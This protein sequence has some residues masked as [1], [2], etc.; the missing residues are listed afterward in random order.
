MREKCVLD[1]RRID[2]FTPRNNHVFHPIVNEHITF[3]IKEPRIASVEIAVTNS[4]L[5]GRI[6]VPIA[7][8][9][10]FS[11]H[12]NLTDLAL[13]HILT[14]FIDNANIDTRIGLAA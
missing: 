11:A 6:I 4:I 7:L 8:H 9:I 2:V 13:R 12:D 14:I 3:I 5:R 1:F 10:A